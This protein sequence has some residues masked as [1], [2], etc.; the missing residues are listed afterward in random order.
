MRHALAAARL[1]VARDT[2]F[3]QKAL[4]YQRFISSDDYLMIGL[5]T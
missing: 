4:L 3:W 5:D 1:L 2:H